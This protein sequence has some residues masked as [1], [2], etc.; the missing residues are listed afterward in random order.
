MDN[1]RS[2]VSLQPRSG[3]RRLLASA[4]TMA[5]ALVGL[6]GA[7]L[8]AAPAAAVPTEAIR[9]L[10][11]CTQESLP[12]NDD[13]SSSQVTL[14]FQM[15]FAGEQRTSLYVNNNG[16]VTF[17]RGLS[18][19]TPEDL[20]GATGNAM[21]AP[22]FA[23]IDTR[24][25]DSAQVTYGASDTQFCVNWVGV[26]YF[27]SN[28]DKL[29]SAQLVI[30]DRSGA[31]GNEGDVGLEFNYSD[32][33]WE[34]GDFS[35]GSGGLGGT[36]VAVGYTAGTGEAG[37]YQQFTG[38]LVNGALVDGGPNALVASS[39]NSDVL[40]RYT[41][42]LG[43]E[44]I[45]QEG[46]L[47]GTVTDED[48][49]PVSAEIR[50][51]PADGGDCVTVPTTE[52]GAYSA[53][54]LQVGDYDV[55]A[56]PAL[57]SGLASLTLPATIIAGEDTT[58]DFV[59]AP[60]VYGGLEVT[61]VDWDGNPVADADAD[62]CVSGTETCLPVVTDEDGTITDGAVP[63]GDYTVSVTAPEGSGLQNGSAEVTVEEE[64]T[65]S[66]TIVLLPVP[67]R[68]ITGIVEDQHGEPVE[69]ATVSLELDRNDEI[70]LLPE[71]SPLLSVDTPQNP[72]TTGDDGA[73]AWGVVDAAYQVTAE[74][75]TCEAVSTR[76]EEF[77]EEGAAHV[78]ITL[79]CVEPTPTP[80]PT[81]DP[82][83]DPT[84]D[85][86]TTGP[87]S[88]SGSP[89]SPGSSG[90]ELPATGVESTVLGGIALML[91]AS[92]AVV[93]ARRRSLGMTN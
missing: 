19:Y 10:D 84:T 56:V 87:T 69:G 61:V 37:T 8:I 32:I 45:V 30:T 82:T 24:H 1:S 51:C 25:E 65:A 21:I 63:T 9:E 16:N 41:F 89:T 90:D 50:I 76:I 17:D 58:L 91:V 48:D 86:P 43:G 39:R 73:F 7:G 80:T 34:T 66:I 14:P 42:A 15:N 5:V 31:T 12:R 28:A 22:F 20:T 53:V 85:G 38:S 77:D 6:V 54:G 57:D 26:G 68:A 2:A 70:V 40:G 74:A 72:Q 79:D 83:E 75:A 29:V 64:Q 93:L 52:A 18:Q 33:G 78:V 81:E 3:V 47:V 49:N 62:L 60:V 11:F 35:G 92:G 46:T 23:D 67:D 55:T 88:P 44:D 36:S 71:G 27:N 59:L 13:G 4:T